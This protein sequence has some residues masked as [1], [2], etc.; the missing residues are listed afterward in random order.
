MTVPPLRPA[1]ASRALVTG[2]LLVLLALLAACGSDP[3]SGPDSS[4]SGDRSGPETGLDTTT[5]P[6]DEPVSVVA[7]GDVVCDPDYVPADPEVECQD[8]ATADLTSRIDPEVVIGLGDLQYEDG[9]LADFESTWSKG[10]G[11]FANILQPVPGNHEYKTTDADGYFEYFDIGDYYVREIG[12]WRVY[13]LDA[14]CE[15]VDCEEEAAW[16]SKDLADNPTECAAI[17][18]HQPRWSSGDHGSQPVVAPL[19]DAAVEGGVDLALAGHDHSYE[20]FARLD[21]SGAPTEDDNG[22]RQFV[23]GTGG[24]SLYEL[25]DPIAGSEAGEDGVFGVLHLT[26]SPGAY[27]WEFVGVD[28]AVLDSGSDT[29][30]G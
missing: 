27:D 21:A 18:T 6:T 8:T 17:A 19:W 1:S 11:R 23:I 2:A 30:R 24:R 10:W 20:R 26:L 12:G 3:A 28:D 14:N 7:V 29:C 16:L 4:P 5:L 25:N 22:A 15:E 13:L 9:E